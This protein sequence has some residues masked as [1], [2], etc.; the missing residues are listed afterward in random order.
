M[1]KSN[2]VYT[3]KKN[4]LSDIL[5]SRFF[6]QVFLL[7]HNFEIYVHRE[8]YDLKYVYAYLHTHIPTY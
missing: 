7:N 3:C 4:F 8:L 6:I 5:I 1:Y 2:I